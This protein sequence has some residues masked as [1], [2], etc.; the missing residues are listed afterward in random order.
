M[1]EKRI[2]AIIRNAQVN[3]IGTIK[4]FYAQL[5]PDVSN[6][7]EDILYLMDDSNA[8]CLII[9]KENKPVG[10]VICYVRPSLSSGKK[11]VIDDLVID[12]QYRRQGL[13]SFLMRHCFEMAEAEDL[14]CVELACSLKRDDLH[15][16][17]EKMGLKH[18]MR[19]YSLIVKR[20]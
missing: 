14:D 4:E 11:M 5:S 2:E 13:G 20:S 15:R 17:Y 18:R 19:L 8:R 12:H 1:K 3:D 10:M 7:E 6:V 9:E 16:F